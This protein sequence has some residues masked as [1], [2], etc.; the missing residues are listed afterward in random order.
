MFGN[1]IV[2]NREQEMASFGKIDYDKEQEEE[3]EEGDDED[4]SPKKKKK[5]KK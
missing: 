5:H 3:Q 2:R 4:G 1:P